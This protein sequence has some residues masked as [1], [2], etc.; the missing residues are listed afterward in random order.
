MTRLLLATTTTTKE[1][2]MNAT[3]LDADRLYRELTYRPDGRLAAQIRSAYAVV[4]AAGEPPQLP[5]W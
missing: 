3:S 1:I 5:R 2:T 4:A